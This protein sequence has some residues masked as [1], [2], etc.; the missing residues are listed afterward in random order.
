MSVTWAGQN[1]TIGVG[2]VGTPVGPAGGDLGG[3]YPNPT[4]DGLQ[5]SPVSS[6]APTTGYALVWSGTEWAPAL[7]TA[8]IADGDKGDITVSASGTTWTI[9][10]QAVTYGKMQHC[11]A[12]SLLG[13]GSGNGQIAEISCTAAGRALLD[14]ADAAAQRTTLGISTAGGDLTGT[15]PN[16]TI[17]SIGG[18]ALAGQAAGRVL[19]ANGSGGVKPSRTFDPSTTAVLFTEA[20]TTSWND[21]NAFQAGTGA[22][23]VASHTADPRVGIALSDTGTTATG[24]AGLATATLFTHQAG[25]S[26]LYF[27][28]ALY[29]DDLSDGTNTFIIHAGFFDSLTAAGTNGIRFEYTDAAGTGAQWDCVTR[30]AST[31][32]RTAVGANVVLQQWYKLAILVNAAGSSVEFYIDGTLV[33]T[34][35]TNI[36][37]GTGKRMG[38]GYNIRKTVGIGQK[39]LWCDYIFVEQGVTR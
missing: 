36:P 23:T 38:S 16:P 37:T 2:T 4:V 25:T 28:T 3:S 33:A 17:A 8:S 18:M 5:G 30:D 35:T 15:Y 19:R 10:G 14:D 32:T 11:T 21:F 24:R 31:E 27:E 20:C 1:V 22:G 39:D 29:L 7:V 13:R 26:E 9:D 12:D 6:T 34:H